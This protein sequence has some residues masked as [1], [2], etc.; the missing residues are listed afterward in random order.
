[1][2]FFKNSFSS[3]GEAL[4][5]VSLAIGLFVTTVTGVGYIYNII[6]EQEAHAQKLA[7]HDTL[8]TGLDGRVRVL[9]DEKT[10]QQ[11]VRY[12]VDRLEKKTDVNSDKLDKVLESIGDLREDLARNSGGR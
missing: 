4:R 6:N 7:S 1:M 8:I 5:T 2:S 9:E 3:F 10:E 12:R 11:L